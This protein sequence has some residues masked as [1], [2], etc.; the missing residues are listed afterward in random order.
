MG[1]EC[2]DHL[3]HGYWKREKRTMEKMRMIGKYVV[4]S[5]A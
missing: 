2:L 3:Q 1:I 5:M 4:V